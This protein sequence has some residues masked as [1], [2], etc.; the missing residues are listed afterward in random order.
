MPYISVE[1]CNNVDSKCAAWDANKYE[2]EDGK[3][4]M[5]S[6]HQPLRLSNNAD[7]DSYEVGD[8]ISATNINKIQLALS[9]E[10]EARSKHV[11]YSQVGT[12][13][14]ITPHGEIID[15]IQH[16]DIDEYVVYLN[17]IVNSNTSFGDTTLGKKPLTLTEVLE[18]DIVQT[19]QLKNVEKQLSK[20][21]KGTTEDCICYSDC[22]NFY[23]GSINKWIC[24]CNGNCG[25]V[26]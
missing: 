18:G 15:D 2:N 5:C 3:R 23:T 13:N 25:C 21:L 4:Y 6:G 17:S 7:F 19:H 16:D 11:L 1:V 22:T 10:L 9:T 20:K 26:Y 24:S 14:D 12:F 8:I